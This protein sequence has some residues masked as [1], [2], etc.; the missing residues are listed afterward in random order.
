[1]NQPF[2]KVSTSDNP[3]ISSGTVKVST[4]VDPTKYQSGY[5]KVTTK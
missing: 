1:M 2:V 5:V 3:N 4:S